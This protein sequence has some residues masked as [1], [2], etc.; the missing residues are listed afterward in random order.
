[1]HK[2]DVIIDDQVYDLKTVKVAKKQK[3]HYNETIFCWTMWGIGWYTER[4]G[5]WL[6]D[7]RT[8]FIGPWALVFYR[9]D[10]GEAGN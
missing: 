10:N 1:M 9:G 2:P 6:P 3:W 8:V 7:E 5:G 4:N